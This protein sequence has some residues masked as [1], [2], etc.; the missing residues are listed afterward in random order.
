MPSSKGFLSW[1]PVSRPLRLADLAHAGPADQVGGLLADHDRG[2][3]DPQALHATNPERRVHDR[4]VVVLAHSFPGLPLSP[5]S[6]PISPLVSS[7][8]T[9]Q[10]VKCK[11]FA[12][13]TRGSAR[14]R[15][16]FCDALIHAGAAMKAGR[17]ARFASSP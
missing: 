10:P 16:C 15:L 17:W 2:V 7:T 4:D 1:G 3:G 13:I 9:E 14:V 11:S 8:I 5:T 12:G 6:F